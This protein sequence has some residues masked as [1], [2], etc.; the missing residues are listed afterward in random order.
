M[1]TGLTQHRQQSDNFPSLSSNT[2]P[3]QNNVTRWL[4]FI[5]L[6]LL[7]EFA[8]GYLEYNRRLAGMSP[9]DTLLSFTIF[10]SVILTVGTYGFYVAVGLCLFMLYVS[11]AKVN[12]RAL[13]FKC[14][15]WSFFF[16][17]LRPYMGYLSV[18]DRVMALRCMS[19]YLQA[20]IIYKHSD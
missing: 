7:I 15:V 20:G 2:I 9:H 18:K 4:C 14:V 5:F 6:F 17:S 8:L 11:I 3:A 19:S 10:S 1:N 13:T 12:K 16:I